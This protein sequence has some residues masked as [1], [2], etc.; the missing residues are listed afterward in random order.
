MGH[1]K[2][3]RKPKMICVC[4]LFNLSRLFLVIIIT[5]H[6]FISSNFREVTAL[7]GNNNSNDNKL[8]QPPTDYYSRTDPYNYDDTIRRQGNCSR[9]IQRADS[10]TMA[11]NRNF[12]HQQRIQED[13]QQIDAPNT[14]DQQYSYAA[15]RPFGD[16]DRYQQGNTPPPPFP[17]G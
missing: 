2:M 12:P 15:N 5:V 4:F 7:E 6:I 8:P 13:Y 1:K 9:R 14:R 10:T 17:L 11:S 16:D 3:K